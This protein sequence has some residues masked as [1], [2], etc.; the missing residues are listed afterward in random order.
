MHETGVCDCCGKSSDDLM[1]S[2]C[3]DKTRW[4]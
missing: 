4:G 1:P 3:S 2:F